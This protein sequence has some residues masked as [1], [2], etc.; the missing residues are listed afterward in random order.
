MNIINEIISTT[1]SSAFTFK[2]LDKS[3]NYSVLGLVLPNS[4]FE[5]VC[6]V[7]FINSANCSCESSFIF[8]KL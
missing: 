1:N 5:I 8:L 4:Q 6:L 7:T 2:T 3:F